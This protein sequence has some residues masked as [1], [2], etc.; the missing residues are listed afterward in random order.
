MLCMRDGFWAL[1][2]SLSNEV[3]DMRLGGWERGHCYVFPS[4]IAV[5]YLSSRISS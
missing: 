2:T 1:E 5:A 3:E 4:K